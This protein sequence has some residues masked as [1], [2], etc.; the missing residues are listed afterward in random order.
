[1]LLI[2]PVREA[3]GFNRVRR[4]GARGSRARPMHMIHAASGRTGVRDPVV[5]PV[6][7]RV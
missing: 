4:T 7:R 1:M 2:W 3:D 5:R 6:G